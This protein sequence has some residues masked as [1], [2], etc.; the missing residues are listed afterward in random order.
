MNKRQGGLTRMHVTTV[1]KRD[2]QNK[3]KRL[4][5]RVSGGCAGAISCPHPLQAIY[6]IYK[7]AIDVVIL[8]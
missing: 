5:N 7:Q 4:I 6:A 2:Q 8:P 1:Q 3:L